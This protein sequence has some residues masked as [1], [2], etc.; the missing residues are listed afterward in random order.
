M[1]GRIVRVP[2]NYNPETRT[3]ATG[4]TGTSNGVWDGTFK[5]AYTNNP[6]WVFYDLVLHPYYGLGER[7]DATMV[8][9]W[10]LY[11]IAKYCDQ[12]VPDGK[13]GQEPRFTCNLYFQKQA[14]A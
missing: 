11:R 10:S 12:M 2:T 5:D 6:A 14:E 3:Y 1:R 4:G 8:D 13:G 9:R 7:I